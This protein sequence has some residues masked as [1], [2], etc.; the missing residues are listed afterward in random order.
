VDLPGSNVS[1]WA[2]CGEQRFLAQVD[3][4]K[5]EYLIISFKTLGL[6]LSIALRLSFEI[7]RSRASLGVSHL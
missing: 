3:L 6:P 1:D 2:Y 5:G 4:T 7:G